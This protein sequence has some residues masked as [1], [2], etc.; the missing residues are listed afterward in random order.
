[1][2]LESVNKAAIS[3][4]TLATLN[5]SGRLAKTLISKI[6]SS[7]PRYFNTSSLPTSASR[8]NSSIPL[9]CSSL[10]YLEST[11]SSNNEQHI[12]LDSTPLM[13]EALIS[14]P[15]NLAPTRETITFS[16]FL[17]LGAPHTI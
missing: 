17:A 16:P 1:M 7:S 5:K 6:T 14:P 12:P 9:V 15:I 11:P 13:T 2:I 10:K 4:A 3:L 8:G